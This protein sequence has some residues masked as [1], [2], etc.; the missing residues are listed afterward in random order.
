M[1]THV[2]KKDL[3]Q[4]VYGSFIPHGHKLETVQVFIH[5]RADKQIVVCLYSGLLL[6]AKRK[7][8]PMQTT[9]WI[10]LINIIPSEKS[11]MQ[12]RIYC[13]GCCLLSSGLGK[14]IYGRRKVQRVI[15]HGRVGA[16]IGKKEH[17][18]TFW[19][20]VRP[21]VFLGLWIS[22]MRAFVKTQNVHLRFVY[23]ILCTFYL[24]HK[25][26]RPRSSS[27][28]YAYWSVGSKRCWCLQVGSA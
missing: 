10:H 23:F 13:I 26:K 7:H 3:S 24:W 20:M 2:H 21:Y 27:K 12:R 4:N 19:V 8:T 22:H 1:K 5:K 9:I 14:L 11:Q 25:K 18:G 6:S 16:G 28:W 17:K 15:F